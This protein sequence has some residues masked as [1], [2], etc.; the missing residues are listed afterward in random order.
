MLTNKPTNNPFVHTA[1]STPRVMLDVVIALLPGIVAAYLAFGAVAL[2]LIAVSVGSALVAEFVFS[3]LFIG[4]I[5]TL[6]DGSAVV[7]G[8]LMAFT[9]GAFTPL[10]AVS[11]GAAAAVIFGKLLWGGLGRNV[12]NPA[13]V[14]REFMTVFFPVAMTSGSVWYNQAAVNHATLQ[15][16]GSRFVDQLFFHPS[17]AVGEYSVVALIIGGLYLLLRRRIT[18]HVPF[19]LL[20]AFTATVALLR[21]CGVEG[22]DFSLGGVLLG[23]VFMATDM[24][25]SPTTTAGRCYY[26]TMIGLVAAVL[27]ACGVRYEYMS[28]SILLLNGAAPFIDRCLRPRVWGLSLDKRARLVRYALLTLTVA[29]ACAIVGMPLFSSIHAVRYIV[30]AYVLVI[31][32]HYVRNDLRTEATVSA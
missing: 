16:T 21:A 22:M 20:T 14:G 5:D 15:L 8:L 9:L 19:S 23:A 27:I 29:A 7:T 10:P 13:L 12:F 4:R 26:G 31:V 18:W 24:P 3:L 6:A 32:V 25:S 1:D 11:F 30:Y 17:G 2:S 28:F